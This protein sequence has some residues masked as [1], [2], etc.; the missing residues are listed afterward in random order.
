MENHGLIALGKTAG[1]VESITAM[2]VKACRVLQGA[3]ALGRVNTVHSSFTQAGRLGPRRGRC[4][5]TALRGI[6]TKVT[7]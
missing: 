1:E 6:S 7:T 3:A 4:G 2:C 5:G